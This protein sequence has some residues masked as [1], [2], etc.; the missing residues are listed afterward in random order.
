MSQ[1]IPLK[2]PGIFGL[3]VPKDFT[4]TKD[5]LRFDFPEIEKYVD[6]EL[7]G[8]ATKDELSFDPEPYVEKSSIKQCWDDFL[9]TV[10]KNYNASETDYVGKY[11][12][13][14]ADSF[15][16]SF[17]SDLYFVNPLGE[18]PSFLGEKY[19]TDNLIS[20]SENYKNDLVKWRE[21]E[22]NK[23]DKVLIIKAK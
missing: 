2:I 21:L 10:Y 5:K 22:S 19:K 15:R 13:I 17:P 4:T 9:S 6:F 16:S 3:K 11:F 7:L 23:A 20:D 12:Q 14:A 8:I 18:R 1:L